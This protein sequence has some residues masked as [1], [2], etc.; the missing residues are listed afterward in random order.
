LYAP[1][2]P[3]KLTAGRSIFF[4]T[5]VLVVFGSRFRSRSS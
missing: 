4:V 2:A 5:R 1:L 3:L